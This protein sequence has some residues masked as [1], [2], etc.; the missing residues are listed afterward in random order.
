MV[1]NSSARM[2][3]VKF[4]LD[5]LL[6]GAVVS[7]LGSCVKIPTLVPQLAAVATASNTAR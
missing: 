4:Y 3:H 2:R 6:R 1:V 7:G 5:I